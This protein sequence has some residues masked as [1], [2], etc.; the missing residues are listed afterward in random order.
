MDLHTNRKRKY[1]E[2]VKGESTK[3]KKKIR[4]WRLGK[5]EWHSREWKREK[6]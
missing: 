3:T 6:R 5:R 2:R 4:P 1:L